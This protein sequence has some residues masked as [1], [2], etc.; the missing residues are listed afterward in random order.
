MRYKTP[1]GTTVQCPTCDAEVIKRRKSH[2]C[3]DC[4]RS[5]WRA[6][7]RARDERNTKVDRDQQHTSRTW[8]HARS[9]EML[10]RPLICPV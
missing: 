9:V 7:K 6:A 3:D 1:I 5:E 8:D 2:K 10:R 4:L